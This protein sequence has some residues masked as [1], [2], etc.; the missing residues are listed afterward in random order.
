M[1]TVA[2]LNTVER[3]ELFRET[4]L[5]KINILPAIVEKDFWVCWTLKRLF[6]LTNLSER[7]IFKGGTSL[8]KVFNVINRFS[9]DIDL[10]FDRSMLG[11]DGERNPSDNMSN[12]K[13]KKLL[14]EL[15]VA[16]EQHVAK[17]LLPMLEKDFSSIIGDSEP[18][19]WKIAID[20]Y[21]KQT[22][23]FKYP[24]GI[25]E[26]EVKIPEYIPPFIKLEMGARSDPWPSGDYRIQS[27]AAEEYPDYF[28][29][30]FC[31]VHTLNAERTFWEKATLLHAEYHRPGKGE[32]RE[33][34]SRH[35]FD[36]A[37]LAKSEFKDK[38]ISDMGLLKAVI[39][40]KLLFFYSSWANYRSVS[41]GNLHLVPKKERISD[42]V[43]DYEKTK[44]M[45]FGDAPSFEEILE[46][47]N[48]LEKEINEKIISGVII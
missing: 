9:E 40:H 28:S 24:T 23:F 21:D 48:G 45:I 1:D 15:S 37:L 34:L 4:S 26:T 18:G 35:Y 10:S 27:Y 39:N 31:T 43:R 3:A 38:A 5:R 30:P 46:I 44:D 12:S 36:L 7:M 19:N 25:A 13:R 6:A 16:C 47:L 22:L 33:R 41:S 42:I 11:F 8:S 17:Q 32:T 20:E 14:K 29:D 2:K